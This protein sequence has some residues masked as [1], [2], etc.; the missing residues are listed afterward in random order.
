MR[1]QAKIGKYKSRQI[2]ET[3]RFGDLQVSWSNRRLIMP[4]TAV[5]LAVFVACTG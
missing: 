3:T 1:T 2:A 5:Q 4:A